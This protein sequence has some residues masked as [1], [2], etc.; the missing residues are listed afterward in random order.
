MMAPYRTAVVALICASAIALAASARADIR[1]TDDAA[2]VIALTRPAARII[3]LAPHVTELLFAAG[4]G[5]H[6]VG[7]TRYSDYPPAAQSI[8]RI[9]DSF[10][11]DSERILALKP[12]LIFAAATFSV[13]ALQRETRS[14]PIVFAQSADPVAEG[15][16]ASLSRPGGNITGFS[17]FE[18]SIGAKWVELL[19]Q[20]APSMTRVAAFYD[21]SNPGAAGFL[22]MVE[23]GARSLSVE[24]STFAIREAHAIEPA[25]KAF[26][27]HSNGGLILLPSPL[28]TTQRD[29]IISLANQ[30]R[31]PTV[32]AYR[33]Y[34][35]GGALAAYGTDNIN[36][37][38]RA[39]SYV[40]RILKGEKPADLSVQQATKFELIINLKTA[41]ALGLEVPVAL[42]ARTDEVIE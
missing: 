8:P 11:V 41:R 20:I 35:A 25:I 9:G 40:D 28:M 14:I 12:E 19:K 2:E 16:V 37:Y 39:A 22:P 18:L 10:V 1:V 34:P 23:S 29:L 30:H 4:A 27:Q 21:P 13:A 7:A 33:Y 5:S 24:A 17:N 3:S 31:L 36:L 32:G 6:I 38:Q 42:L 26:A 15:L